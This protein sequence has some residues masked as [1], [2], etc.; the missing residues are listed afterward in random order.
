MGINYKTI[1]PT[2]DYAPVTTHSPSITKSFKVKNTGIADVK[3]DWKIFDQDT[4]EAHRQT[5]MFKI[6]IVKRAGATHPDRQYKL[7]FDIEEPEPSE[8]SAF[9]LIKPDSPVV[10]ANSFATFG[11]RFNSDHGLGHFNSII[12]ANPELDTENV[13]VSSLGVVAVR[14]TA[15]T[16][17]PR[18]SID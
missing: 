2:I 18:L 8:N 1:P 6:Q 10:R 13:T 5:D 14:L 15:S 7:K 11:I 17:S 3:L 4:L 9:E 12:L 16:Q